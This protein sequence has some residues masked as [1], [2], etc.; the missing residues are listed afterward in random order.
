M[1][2]CICFSRFCRIAV[3]RLGRSSKYLRQEK[4]QTQTSIAASMNR[5]SFANIGS[6]MVSPR[7]L[8]IPCGRKS[9]V[10]PDGVSV[11]LHI[12]DRTEAFRVLA[13]SV[14][15]TV[16]MVLVDRTS[17]PRSVVSTHM[18]ATAAL[19]WSAATTP[20]SMWYVS[21]ST[22]DKN[23]FVHVQQVTGCCDC[24]ASFLT[25]VRLSHSLAVI[26]CATSVTDAANLEK[27][28]FSS[29]V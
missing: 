13:Q 21:A 1:A 14:I 17:Q 16:W 24:H 11:V 20:N 27:S 4:T 26:I 19:K 3:S 29:S 22:V 9:I 25:S 2:L 6:S 15:H 10:L 8:H 12:T 18:S 23:A 5:S 7:P 28:Y